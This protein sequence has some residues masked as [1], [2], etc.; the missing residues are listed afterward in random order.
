VPTGRAWSGSLVA[1]AEISRSVR[2]HVS[3]F[4]PARACIGNP[5]LPVIK[6]CANRERCTMGEHVD[7]DTSGRCSDHDSDAGDKLPMMFR[8]ASS[9]P[10]PPGAVCEFNDPPL[11]ERLK[12]LFRGCGRTS[13]FA[14]RETGG[15]PM[16]KF[17]MRVALLLATAVPST[18]CPPRC[19]DQRRVQYA[20]A[21]CR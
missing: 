21:T 7:L 2:L 9:R 8:T 13:D 12:H 5:I 10:P 4:P 15:V 11:R 3:I 20:S 14:W 18:A 6:I 17:R 19:R 1:A 16:Q